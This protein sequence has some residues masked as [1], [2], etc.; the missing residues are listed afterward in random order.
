[1]RLGM[2]LSELQDEKSSAYGFS[3]YDA[4]SGHGYGHLGKARF[5]GA[6]IQQQGSY[7]YFDPGNKLKD[8][9]PDCFSEEG[10]DPESYDADASMDDDE[11]VQFSNRVGMSAPEHDQ[12][13]VS[14]N[15]RDR[16][17]FIDGSTRLDLAWRV[18]SPSLASVLLHERIFTPDARDNGYWSRVSGTTRGWSG[19]P[20]DYFDEFDDDAYEPG[21]FEDPDDRAVTRA[22]ESEID[23]RIG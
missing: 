15:T 4:R 21:D 2:L 23:S 10:C 20:R 18:R 14:M 1:M 19:A 17:S 5:S 7:P 13:S 16:T 12:M 9:F 22:R 3:G 6:E 11:Y 8:A